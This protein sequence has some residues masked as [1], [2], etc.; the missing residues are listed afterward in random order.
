MAVIEDVF[1]SKGE[2][3]ILKVLADIGEL[4]ARAQMAR[5]D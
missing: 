5:R 4:N 3:K 2:M 1:S